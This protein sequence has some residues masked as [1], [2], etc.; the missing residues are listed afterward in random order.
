LFKGREFYR[1]FHEQDHEYSGVDDEPEEECGY[2]KWD[3]LCSGGCRSKIINT[4]CGYKFEKKKEEE[5]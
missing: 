3:E 4:V 5:I 2:C 1:E